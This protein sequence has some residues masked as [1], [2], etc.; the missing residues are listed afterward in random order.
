MRI[1][2]L[3]EQSKS[4]LKKVLA[5]RSTGKMTDLEKTVDDIITNVKAPC[6]EG[7]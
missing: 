1:I 7:F 3:N 2:K 5:S 4:E 6:L